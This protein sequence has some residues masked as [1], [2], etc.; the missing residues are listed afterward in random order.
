MSRRNVP[1][2][3]GQLLTG[4]RGERDRRGYLVTHVVHR[5]PDG[6]PVLKLVDIDK[7][8]RCM[9]ERRCQTCGLAIEADEWLGFIGPV[10]SAEYK[11]APIHLR[12][13]RYSFRMCPHLRS[14]T[15][16]ESIQIA[17]CRAYEYRPRS[18][19]DVA[20]GRPPV[21]VPSAVTDEAL[22]AEA[23]GL[24]PGTARG[25]GVVVLS[26]ADLEGWVEAAA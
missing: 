3:P 8:D 26:P 20:A 14:G 19:S 15:R 22:V 11:E 7:A 6:T 25:D 21:C 17:V 5:E 9:A 18:K 23:A 24:A 4:M 12:C 2:P 16:E 10:G 13:A 1:I